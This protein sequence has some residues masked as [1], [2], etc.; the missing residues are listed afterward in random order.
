[1]LKEVSILIDQGKYLRLAASRLISLLLPH[2]PVLCLEERMNGSHE[3]SLLD[4]PILFG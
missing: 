3:Q 2:R 1:M 4:G